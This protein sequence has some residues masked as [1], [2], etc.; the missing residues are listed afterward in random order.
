MFANLVQNQTNFEQVLVRF[1]RNKVTFFGSFGS[2]PCIAIFFF[3]VN[4]KVARTKIHEEKQQS[5]P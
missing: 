4:Y 5:Q 1:K 3:F 2:I